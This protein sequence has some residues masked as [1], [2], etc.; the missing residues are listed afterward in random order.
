MA[1]KKEF[2]KITVDKL[3]SMSTSTYSELVEKDGFYGKEVFCTEGFNESVFS[4]Y[5]C[6]GNIGAHPNQK[7]ME[8]DIEFIIVSDKIINYPNSELCR[9]FI[10]DYEKKINQTNSS[11]SRVKIITETELIKYLTARAKKFNDEILLELIKRYNHKPTVN[12][13]PTLF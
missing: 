11:Y 6:L 2:V 8:P 7:V 1:K 4:L 10:E 9:S 12:P 13:N 3:K 5:Q